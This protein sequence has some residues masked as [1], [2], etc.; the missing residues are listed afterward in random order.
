MTL[1]NLLRIGKL[2][3]HAVDKVEIARL[4][5]AAERVRVLDA[6]RAPPGTSTVIARTR[7][8]TSIS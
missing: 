4:F 5:A 8:R 3:A 2:R 6:Y 7:P 1:A